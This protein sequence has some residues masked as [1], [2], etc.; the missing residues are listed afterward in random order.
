MAA[1][2]IQSEIDPKSSAQPAPT[3]GSTLPEIRFNAIFP[4]ATPSAPRATKGDASSGAIVTGAL[5]RRQRCGRD[6]G[7]TNSKDEPAHA[8]DGLLEDNGTN[9]GCNERLDVGEHRRR[10][11]SDASACQEHAREAK[12][13]KPKPATP[14]Q[15]KVLA[16]G[17][18]RPCSLA[19]ASSV[20]PARVALH[21]P[22]E[23]GGAPLGRI[24]AG[25]NEPK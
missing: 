6:T 19:M 16:V 17:R 25:F 4:T 1:E 3:T 12:C 9:Q 11:R 8:T 18:V 22:I 5:Q 15:R 21:A 7:K 2:M 20:A 13:C 10:A 23:R 14:R 24:S